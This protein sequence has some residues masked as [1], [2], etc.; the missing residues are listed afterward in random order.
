M[1]IIKVGD[2][3]IEQHLKGEDDN[4]YTWW[5]AKIEHC[6]DNDQILTIGAME[7]RY[8]TL[9]IRSRQGD[10]LDGIEL[11]HQQVAQLVAC[12]EYLLQNA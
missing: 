3:E 12:L 10:F 9:I 8:M 5:D 1:N 6:G 7:D 4:P 2:I 11:S